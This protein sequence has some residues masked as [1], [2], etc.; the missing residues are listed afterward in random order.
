MPDSAPTSRDAFF[1]RIHAALGRSATATPS[2][3]P[4]EVD[5]TI[6]RLANHSDD[7]VKMFHTRAAG[8]G[9]FVHRPKAS[10]L[11]DHLIA[12]LKKEGVKS[13]VLGQ[14]PLLGD[15]DA[16]LRE[17][18]FE[19]VDWKKSEGLDV[20]FDVD[21][22]ITSVAAALAETGTLVICSTANTSRGLSLVP[23]LH[24]AIVR[25]SDILPDML[26]YWHRLK[27][28]PNTDLPSNMVFITGPSKTADIEG[29]L[30]TG[31]HGPEAVHILLVEE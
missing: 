4:P 29:E 1:A 17:A 9:M 27:G 15:L 7:I 2:E 11:A 12:F 22:G 10:E 3:K 21:C 28:V 13:V 26:D 30:V 31:V 23:P 19:V 8:T 18:G 14:L 5:E 20:Q 25:E 24:I 16:K 6:A